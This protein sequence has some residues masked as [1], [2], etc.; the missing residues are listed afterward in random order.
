MGAK[1]YRFIK[2]VKAFSKIMEKYYPEMPFK[3]QLAM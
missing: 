3:I 1:I 2:V